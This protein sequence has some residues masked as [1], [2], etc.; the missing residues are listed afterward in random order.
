MLY[1]AVTYERAG[2]R[3]K[4]ITTYRRITELFPNYSPARVNLMVA[5]IEA[6]DRNSAA[7]EAQSA[8]EAI[9]EDPRMKYL[10]RVLG[11]GIT[12]SNDVGVSNA[13]VSAGQP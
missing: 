3:T 7:R 1:E 2:Q 6:G 12:L 5:L 9:P 11:M 8:L 10:A 13:P 4:A